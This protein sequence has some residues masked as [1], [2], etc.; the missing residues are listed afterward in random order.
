MSDAILPIADLKV[1]DRFTLPPKRKK[2]I[3]NREW[4]NT[5]PVPKPDGGYEYLSSC[6]CKTSSG[7]TFDLLRTTLVLKVS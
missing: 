4:G 1:G 5:I 7:R 2:F 6:D 3:K